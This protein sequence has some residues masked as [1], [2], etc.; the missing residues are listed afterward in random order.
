VSG[1]EPGLTIRRTGSPSVFSQSSV[2]K[3]HSSRF[4]SFCARRATAAG[5]LTLPSMAPRSSARQALMLSTRAGVV[6]PGTSTPG[7]GTP[8]TYCVPEPVAVAAAA[9]AAAAA[10]AGAEEAISAS[11]VGKTANG[12]VVG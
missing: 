7:L 6:S 1:A 5:S 3:M 10:E 8:G 12:P 9:A 4:S 11:S 2:S